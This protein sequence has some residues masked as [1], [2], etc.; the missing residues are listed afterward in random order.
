MGEVTKAE[1]VLDRQGSR[2]STH[3]FR[4]GGLPFRDSGGPGGTPTQLG[5]EAGGPACHPATMKRDSA[6]SRVTFTRVRQA[7]S[8]TAFS[9][10]K[11]TGSHG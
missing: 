4:R 6:K 10:S 1:S 3:R 5:P 9:A 8:I 11:I 2:S 7:G